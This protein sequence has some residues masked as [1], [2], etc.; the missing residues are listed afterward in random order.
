MSIDK[1]NILLIAENHQSVRNVI[2][3]EAAYRNIDHE[4]INCS[5]WLMYIDL[6]EF[7]Q[8]SL[9]QSN[10][11]NDDNNVSNNGITEQK[12]NK[13]HHLHSIFEAAHGKYRCSF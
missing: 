1:S 7:C 10:S 11:S 2:H 8:Q 4:L 13:E 5:P 6:I 3:A 9:F 12:E